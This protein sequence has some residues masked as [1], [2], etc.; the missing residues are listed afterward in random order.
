MMDP[1]TAGLVAAGA[2]VA[3]FIKLG[4]TNIRRVLRYDFAVDLIF[5]VILMVFL[6]GTN[7]GAQTALT[8]GLMLSVALWTLKLFIGYEKKI[9]VYC[10][11]CKHK[12]WIWRRVPGK[13]QFVNR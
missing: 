2:I 7:N 10:E 3:L 4:F 1:V 13:F 6:A 11:T 5:T 12:S 9:Q 8:G